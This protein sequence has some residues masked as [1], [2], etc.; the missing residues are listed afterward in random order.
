MY[1]HFT[2]KSG[3]Y[4]KVMIS[5]GKMTD[6]RKAQDIMGSFFMS[7]QRL[8]QLA[9]YL[10]LQFSKLKVHFI[11]LMSPRFLHLLPNFVSDQR[12]WGRDARTE[13]PKLPKKKP[14]VPQ[15]QF[16]ATSFTSVAA[17]LYHVKLTGVNVHKIVSLITISKS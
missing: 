4:K 3:K 2:P 8:I 13:K 5:V 1:R 12:R 16:S 17:E 7:A 14:L 15:R 10:V 6:N 9:L 11:T